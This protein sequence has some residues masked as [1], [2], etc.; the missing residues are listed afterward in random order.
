MISE[1]FTGGEARAFGIDAEGT[2][3]VYDPSSDVLFRNVDN[4]GVPV[5]DSAHGSTN[6]D[7]TQLALQVNGGSWDISLLSQG[8]ILA[9]GLLD[10]NS[11]NSVHMYW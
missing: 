7:Y 6:M 5:K 10:W 4:L 2:A 11:Y 8:T 1:E 3:Y 9:E